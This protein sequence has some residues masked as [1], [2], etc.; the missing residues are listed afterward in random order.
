[1]ISVKRSVIFWRFSAG[2]GDDEDMSLFS[3][4]GTRGQNIRI[5]S[6]HL[7]NTDLF[8]A[9]KPQ[10]QEEFDSVCSD[11]GASV[12]CASFRWEGCPSGLWMQS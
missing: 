1:M 11:R 7:C 5:C 9:D 12:D 2:E 3:Y 4:I 8:L 6:A 10:S